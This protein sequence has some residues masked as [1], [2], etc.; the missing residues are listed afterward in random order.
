MGPYGTCSSN[1][2]FVIEEAAQHWR[3]GWAEDLAVGRHHGETE[4]QGF[5][6]A[7]AVNIVVNLTTAGILFL[8][9]TGRFSPERTVMP[10]AIMA[11]FRKK[12]RRFMIDFS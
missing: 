8:R 3:F 9:R 1:L 2:L 12:S 10:A 11:A 7:V 5:A 6:S 4:E